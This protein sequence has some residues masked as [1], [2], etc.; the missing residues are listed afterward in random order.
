MITAERLQLTVGNNTTVCTLNIG[1]WIMLDLVRYYT[2]SLRRSFFQE[3]SAT[4][5]RYC[6]KCYGDDFVRA[7]LLVIY[8]RCWGY[9]CC[10]SSVIG[11]WTLSLAT[12]WFATCW[13]QPTHVSCCCRGGKFG[14]LLYLALLIEFI[15]AQ[16]P[17]AG[18]SQDATGLLSFVEGWHNLSIFGILQGRFES[19]KIS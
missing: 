8:S 18:K 7:L 1:A 17:G 2:I 13:S 11:I 4:F 6:C 9:C 19:V 16:Y 10:G 15:R 12:A 5:I 14:E 3:G